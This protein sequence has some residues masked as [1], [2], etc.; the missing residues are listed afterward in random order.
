MRFGALGFTPRDGGNVES[1]MPILDLAAR[2]NELQR[3]STALQLSS[4][5]LRQDS[6]VLRREARLLLAQLG[7]WPRIAARR[8]AVESQPRRT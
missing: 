1:A 6:R 7:T 2:L 5:E 8:M 4:R 3:R